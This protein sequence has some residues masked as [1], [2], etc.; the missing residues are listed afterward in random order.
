MAASKLQYN[1]INI[2]IIIISMSGSMMSPRSSPSILTIA[3]N[4]IQQI[5]EKLDRHDEGSLESL[6]H[7]IMNYVERRN[8]LKRPILESLEEETLSIEDLNMANLNV[9]HNESECALMKL[10]QAMT[11][12]GE[13][14]E[15]VQES[16]NRCV[17]DFVCGEDFNE[18]GF[19]LD[20]CKELVMELSKFR[21]V[22]D[23]VGRVQ[24]YRKK[25]KNGQRD[26][27]LLLD[28]EDYLDR[29]DQAMS[30]EE[31]EDSFA[32]DQSSRSTMLLEFI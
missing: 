5:T 7:A 1:I 28:L 29:V 25:N 17:R 22:E 8:E 24:D 11:E 10:Q 20:I 15:A 3:I 21:D 9:V 13:L 14:K 32:P 26:H 12:F 30:D 16:N 2:I 23:I 18:V 27:D 31:N 19:M 4:Y 6:D